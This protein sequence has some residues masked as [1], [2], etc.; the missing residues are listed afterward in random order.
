MRRHV[1]SYAAALAESDD[2]EA[3]VIGNAAVGD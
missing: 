2:R 3:I 1:H